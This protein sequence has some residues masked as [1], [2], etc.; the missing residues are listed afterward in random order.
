MRTAELKLE[1]FRKIDSLSD[2]ELKH[3]YEELLSVLG[4][5][6]PYQLT[7]EENSAIDEALSV[8]DLNLPIETDDVKAEGGQKYKNLRFS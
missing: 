2:E 7:A 5:R 3:V 4:S 1:L 6:H 8:S